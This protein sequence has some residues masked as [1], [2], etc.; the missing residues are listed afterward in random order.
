MAQLS[1]NKNALPIVRELID[2]S[3]AFGVTVERTGLGTTIIDAG[4]ETVGGYMAGKVITEICL[5]GYGEAKLTLDCYEDIHLPCICVTT[6]HPAVATLGSQYAGWG[7]KVGDYFA[8]GSG[9]ARALSLKPKE[10]Y[11]KIDYRD[12]SDVAIILLET[13][14]KPSDEVNKHIAEACRVEASN[15]YVILTPTSSLAASTQISGRIVETGIHKLTELGFDPKKILHGHGCAPIAPVHPKFVRAMGMT[16]DM[17]LY[18]GVTEYIVDYEN[19]EEL[20]DFVE[21]TPSSA[22]K[23]YGKPFYEIFEEAGRDFYKIDPALFAPAS[24]SVTNNRTGK[25]F[26]AGKVNTEILKKSIVM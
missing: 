7:I 10:L 3:Q 26:S 24:I 13:S 6:E 16:N 1:V 20:R 5:G 25:S 21:K 14:K 8:M 23:A 22:S 15:L 9:P 17:I 2:R 18:G 4:I 11:E 19:D 12:E